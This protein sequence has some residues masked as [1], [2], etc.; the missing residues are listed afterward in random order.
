STGSSTGTSDGSS[1]GSSDGSSTG[2]STGTS[3]GSSTGNGGGCQSDADCPSGQVCDAS[4]GQCVAGGGSCEHGICTQGDGVDSSC[5]QCATSI[6]NVDSYCCQYEWD[7]I[8]VGEVSSVCG[9]SCSGGGNG[10]G[11]GDGGSCDHD[12]YTKGD[13]LSPSCDACSGTVCG[14]DSF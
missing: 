10:G 3:D 6:C 5:D 12:E 8:C 13:P 11:G 14:S 4:S 9:L 1:T 2:S 7:S